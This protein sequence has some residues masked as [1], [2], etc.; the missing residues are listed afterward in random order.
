MSA[1]CVSRIAA[2]LIILAPLHARA[3]KILVTNLH[4]N[5]ESKASSY[6]LGDEEPDLVL[7]KDLGDYL[8]P[9]MNDVSSYTESECGIGEAVS[10]T[11]ATATV[12]SLGFEV[13]VM[14]SVTDDPDMQGAGVGTSWFYL[15]FEVDSP[16]TFT[17]TLEAASS[18]TGNPIGVSCQ[19]R[20]EERIGPMLYEYVDSFPDVVDTWNGGVAPGTYQLYGGCVCIHSPRFIPPDT[21]LGYGTST[22]SMRVTV[23][24]DDAIVVANEV[25]TFGM[26][27]ARFTDDR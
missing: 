10:S 21:Y 4:I 27:K 26:F 5:M 17:L 12:S 11:E 20:L 1:T 22:A 23:D 8:P 9:Y 3:A 19:L 2:L 13:A 14:G 7:E 15:D 18:S 6:C 25:T 16:A 24:F